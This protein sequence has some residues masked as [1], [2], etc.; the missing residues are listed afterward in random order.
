MSAHREPEMWILHG[1]QR[2]MLLP[3]DRAYMCVGMYMYIYIYIYIYIVLY[4]HICNICMYFDMSCFRAGGVHNFQT[5]M[6]RIP[7]T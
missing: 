4:V 1:L 6:L 3:G 2:W 5:H 7:Y